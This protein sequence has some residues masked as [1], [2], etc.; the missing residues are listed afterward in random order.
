VKHHPALAYAQVPAFMARLRDEAGTAALALRFAILTAARTG[1][2][3][4]ATW[5]EIDLGARVWTV[6]AA[7]IAFP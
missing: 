4:G 2:V 1:E 3:I 7:S 6:P 5:D